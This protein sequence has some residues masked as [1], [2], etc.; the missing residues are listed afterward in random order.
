[1]SR[2]NRED[3]KDAK[4]RLGSPRCPT[5]RGPATERDQ[6][7]TFPFCSERCRLID[8]GNWLGESYRIPTH[9]SPD[10]HVTEDNET[11]SSN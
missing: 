9:E 8:L 10:D 1:V 7:P 5:C 4:M 3:A 2:L 6:N 11:D